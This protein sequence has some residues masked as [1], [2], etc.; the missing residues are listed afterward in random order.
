VRK[1]QVLDN[2]NSFVSASQDKTVRLWSIRTTEE[3]ATCKWTYKGH[4]KAV[5]DLAVMGWGQFI[6]STGSDSAVHIWDPF[7]GTLVRQLE[8]PST[9][10]S[11]SDTSTPCII[12]TLLA[13]DTHIVA[14]T[15]NLEDTVRTIDVRSGRWAQHFITATPSSSGCFVR[16][17]GVSPSERLMAVALSNGSL[18]VLDL[19]TGRAL[20]HW[21]SSSTDG[22]ADPNISQ[23]E[24]LSETRLASLHS[25]RPVTLWDL[26]PGDSRIS[27][28][29]RLSETASFLLR[30]A[31][32]Q[33]LTAQPPAYRLR[34]YSGDEL[35]LKNPTEV[36][37]RSEFISGQ[38]ATMA[39]LPMNWMFLV[40][41][42]SGMIRLAC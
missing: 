4:A 33:F 34:L 25:D 38:V 14:A 21:S 17:V 18:T 26:S 10:T 27:V 12:S 11:N 32:G 23:L 40:G 15:S 28:S 1:L 41:S 42:S 29:M 9:I 3:A 13:L 5:L 24:W 31:D 22:Q 30:C 39:Q 6:A 35:V 2:E 19:R 7:R 16:A 37:L 8:W 36:R 20:A